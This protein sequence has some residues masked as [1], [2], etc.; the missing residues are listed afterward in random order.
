VI[1][2]TVTGPQGGFNFF[3]D[4]VGFDLS[5]V[6]AI[7]LYEAGNPVA[8]FDPSGELLGVWNAWDHLRVREVTTPEPAPAAL[9]VLAVLVFA[10]L[11]MRRRERA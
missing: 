10:A 6:I 4:D 7:E 1:D 2:P 3:M 5:R 8:A 9:G 11:A